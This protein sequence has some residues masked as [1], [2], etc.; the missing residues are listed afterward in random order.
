MVDRAKKITELSALT[1]PATGDYLI[2][3]DD[4]SGTPETKYITV[5][6]LLNT[7]LI[8]TAALAAAN[9][10][11]KGTVIVSENLSINAT[12]YLSVSV[13]GPYAN[14]EAANTGGIANGSLYY[15]ASGD[16]KIRLS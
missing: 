8:N 6:N 4:P 16:V 14:D 5:G 13:T 12:G 15:T 1:A 7:G 3:E 11:S 9:T 10:T 2:I